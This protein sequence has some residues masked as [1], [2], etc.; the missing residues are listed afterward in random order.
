MTMLP[1]R[2]Q[3]RRLLPLRRPLLP[4]PSNPPPRPRLFTQNSQLL[5]IS[6]SS[7][8]PQ[9]PFLYHSSRL[10]APRPL[11]RSQFQYQLSR[12]LTTERKSYLK[13]QIWLASKYTAY[14]WA[15]LLLLG[16]MAFGVQDARL[17]RKYPSPPC[18]SWVSRMDY[19]TARGQENPDANGTGLI[20]WA[21]TGNEYRQLLGRLEN[22]NLDGQGLRP[23]LEI[24]G[25]IYVEGLGRMGLDV[26]AKP[27]SWRRGYHTCLMGAA[28]AAEHLDGWVRDTT[29]NIAFPG[30]VVIGPSNPRSKPVPLGAKSAPREEN[31]VAAFEPPETYYMKI[32]TTQGFTTRQRLNAALA[33]ADWLDFKGLHSSA[34]EMYDW[35]LDIATGA[36]PTGVNDVVDS[37]TGII[38]EKTTFVSSNVLLAS[39]SLAIHYAR[40]SNLNTALPILLSVLRARRSLVP[41]SQRLQPHTIASPSQHDETEPSTFQ[42]IVSLFRSLMIPPP[43]PSPSPTGDERATRTPAAVCEEA[44]LMT[45]IGEILFASPSTPSQKSSFFSSSQNTRQARAQQSGLSWTRDAVDLAEKTL[46]GVL[47]KSV[48]QL[49]AHEAKKRCS[50]C[51]EVGMGNWAKMVDRMVKVEQEEH[52]RRSKSQGKSGLWATEAGESRW[53]VERRVVDEKKRSVRILVGGLGDD[54]GV[55]VGG[56]SSGGFMI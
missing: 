3:Y 46:Q 41:G 13:T 18:W 28:R 4:I 29:R 1:Q 27:E 48:T 33:Y 12:L 23:P 43:Y 53:E 36:L 30:D 45:Y 7:P 10:R 34:E 50:E 20:D 16:I 24:D 35:G 52:A 49:D 8:R 6:P 32:L 21:R 40:N 47:D 9:L 56:V 51:L 55:C 38:N 5:L 14:G 37:K 54:A 31:C 26:S 11:S 39:T 44:G 19:R 2:M 22:P 15:A 25:D 17:E 42:I